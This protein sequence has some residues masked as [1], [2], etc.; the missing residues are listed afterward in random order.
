MLINNNCESL[1]LPESYLY[2]M[3][4]MPVRKNTLILSSRHDRAPVQDSTMQ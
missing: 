1:D 3:I 4:N 2:G